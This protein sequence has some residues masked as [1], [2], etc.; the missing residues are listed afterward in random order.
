MKEHS[1]H[2]TV[3]LGEDLK[4]AFEDLL[5]NEGLVVRD[6]DALP[7]MAEHILMDVIGKGGA[8]SAVIEES[9]ETASD[10]FADWLEDGSV[11]LNEEEDGS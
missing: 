3:K 4:D 7:S 5:N 8:L 10:F 1:Y 9:G 11:V 6:R 2:T